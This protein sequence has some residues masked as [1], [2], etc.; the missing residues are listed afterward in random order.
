MSERQAMHSRFQLSV[1]AIAL[2]LFGMSIEARA[3]C[4]VP[5]TLTNGTVADANDVMGNFN[6]LGSCAVGTTG[7]PTT[8]SITVF[9]SSGT[10]G[11]GNLSGDVTTSGS[12]ITTLSATGVTAGSYTNSNVTVDAK[13]RV[14]AI[15]NGSAGGSAAEV[16]ITETVTSGS[17]SSVTFSTIPTAYRDLEVRVRALATTGLT[18]FMRFNG[19]GG[20]NY[21]Y[22]YFNHNTSSGTGAS[23]T[24]SDSGLKI[25]AASSGANSAFS[26]T[27]NILNYQSATYKQAL[28]D[29][30]N[31]DGSGGNHGIMG[32]TWKDTSAIS[33]VTVLVS[34]GNFVDGSVISLYG[35]Y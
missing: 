11:S 20:G 24:T 23:G 15:A 4:P 13:G 3:A 10:I 31:T 32:G 1:V 19:D 28:A 2:G 18:L 9:S 8:G 29:H 26:T 27:A 21:S 14:T 16:L 17:Q 30:T 6:A 7:S 22:S 33:S 12:T 34:A 5:N 35:R 25:G